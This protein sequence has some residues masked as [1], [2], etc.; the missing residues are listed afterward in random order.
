[1][2]QHRVFYRR[3]NKRHKKRNNKIDW[4][5]FKPRPNED[6]ITNG[7]SVYWSELR[8]PLE[9]L[10][11]HCELCNRHL[12]AFRECSLTSPVII[13]QKDPKDDSHF[14]ILNFPPDGDDQFQWAKKLANDSKLKILCNNKKIAEEYD[15]P[16]II[17]P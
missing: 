8:C 15:D 11:G 12:A 7:P 3:I 4:H 13:D 16:E 1:M 9:A 14:F 2:C 17:C 10:E 6:G 5:A